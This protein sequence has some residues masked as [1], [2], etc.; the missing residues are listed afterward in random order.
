[1]LETSAKHFFPEEREPIPSVPRHYLPNPFSEVHLH[2]LQRHGG[3][4]FSYDLG[5]VLDDTVFVG[6]T[7]RPVPCLDK[8]L[9]LNTI[10]KF[11]LKDG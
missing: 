1:M 7:H 10:L 11:T 5:R 9:Q 3:L 6:A 8:R 4:E 2:T